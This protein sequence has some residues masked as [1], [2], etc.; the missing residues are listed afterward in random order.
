MGKVLL[1]NLEK[2]DWVVLKCDYAITANSS[3]QN[4]FYH[5]NNKSFKK[6]NIDGILFIKQIVKCFT[7]LMNIIMNKDLLKKMTFEIK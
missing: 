5:W 1:G 3:G 7:I 2:V 4:H 6:V